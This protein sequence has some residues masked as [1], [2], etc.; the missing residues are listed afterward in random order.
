MRPSSLPKLALCG[1]YQSAPGEA[2]PAAQR[3]TRLDATFRD[4]WATGKYPADLPDEDAAAVRWA[5]EALTNC[6]TSERDHVQTSE[7]ATRIPHIPM[8]PNGGTADAV[9]LGGRWLADLK[10]GQVY[11]YKAQMA[12]YALGLMVQ[13]LELEWTCHLLFCDQQRVV[14]HYFRYAEARDIV[15]AAVD[16]VGTPPVIN[17][18]CGWCAYSLTCSARVQAS[19]TALATTPESFTAVLADP[20]RLGEFLTRCRT[21]DDFREAAE[22]E[23]RRLLGE[24]VEVPGWR[25]QK[26][27]VSEF[28]D[29]EIL[30]AA[31]AS[32][33][34][35]AVDVIRAHGTMSAAKARKLWADVPTASKESKAAL[36]ASK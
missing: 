23:C 12:A 1:Q 36:V 7:N 27:R 24:G 10:S 22:T 3:G 30:E 18:Y 2:G 4:A 26:P 8:L 35:N 11:D 21:F 33:Q 34:I 31:V 14:T 19:G 25:L 32:G 16:N 28:V 29:A 9:C 6:R 13:E 20:A 15:K 5:V 17:D